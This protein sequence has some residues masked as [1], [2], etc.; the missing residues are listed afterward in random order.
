MWNWGA[1]LTA[2]TKV[3]QGYANGVTYDANYIYLACGSYGLVVLDKNKME[4]GK[5]VKVVKKRA[6]AGMSA[7]YVTLDGGYIYVAYGKS[8]LRVMKLID[9]AASGNDTNY[10]TK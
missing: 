9:G 2:N 1:P 3:P 6:E 7:N 8:R 5:P 10:G 4:N